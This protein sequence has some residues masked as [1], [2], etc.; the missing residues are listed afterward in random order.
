MART[1]P[2]VALS[3]VLKPHEDAIGQAM[4]A[5]YT[6]G[7]GFDLV[8]RDDGF[9]A[10]AGPAS[11]IAPHRRWPECERRAIKHARGRVLDIGVGAGRHAIYLQERGHD[12]LGTDVSLL[13]LKVARARGL[14]RTRA[15]AIT[16]ITRKLGVFDTILMFGNNFGLMTDATRCRW[17]LRRFKGMMPPQGRIIASTTDVYGTDD[18]AHLAY[19]RRNR[20]RG[21]MGGQIRM[22][23]R[24]RHFC[25]PWFDYLMVSLKEMTQLVDGTGWRI[26]RHYEGPGPLYAVVLE[27][28]DA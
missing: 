25:T 11:Y 16:Q 8:E 1:Q 13:A 19:H 23:I 10:P 18:N 7:E 12:V 20:G 3:R 17:L 6:T 22:R 26:A 24:H 9:I 28:T 27:R 14:R 2:A 5:Q 21:R 15:M 4:Y